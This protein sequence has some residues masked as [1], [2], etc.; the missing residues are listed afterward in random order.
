MVIFVEVFGRVFI[1]RGITTTHMPTDEAKA[2]VNPGVADLYAFFADVRAGGLD[3]DL[4]E[5][6]ASVVHFSSS[7]YWRARVK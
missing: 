4:I 3:L 6:G 7:E 2:Q 5:V 1:P